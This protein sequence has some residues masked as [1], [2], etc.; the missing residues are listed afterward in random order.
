MIGPRRLYFLNRRIP[1]PLSIE[2]LIWPSS[3]PAQSLREPCAL[4]S[5]ATLRSASSPPHVR[6]LLRACAGTGASPHESS[7]TCSGGPRP[8]DPALA[9]RRFR[10]PGGGA[11][12]MGCDKR[13]R[14]PRR[15]GGA[16]PRATNQAD[17]THAGA[18][19]AMVQDELQ[20]KLMRTS[21]PGGLL[22]Q[23]HRV[24]LNQS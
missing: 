5:P 20:S 17:A 7:P 2:P 19:V 3:L 11:I 15:R 16:G 1:E 14:W 18:A 9:N 8:V 13:A 21:T 23:W 24:S 12:R 6:C 22:W 10:A 4:P